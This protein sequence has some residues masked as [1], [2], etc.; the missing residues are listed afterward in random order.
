MTQS[1]LGLVRMLRQN[2][3][4]YCEIRSAGN[5]GKFPWRLKNMWYHAV[6]DMIHRSETVFRLRL[7]NNGILFTKKMPSVKNTSLCIFS[8]SKGI[9]TESLVT[10][11]GL[12]LV[13]F[14]FSAAM[15]LSQIFRETLTS[16]TVTGQSLIWFLLIT[17]LKSFQDMYHNLAY[18]F[19]ADFVLLM[20]L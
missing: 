2:A 8:K 20:C 14:P 17:F 18:I 7:K 3:S 4:S 13:D 10:V 6:Q 11:F 9:F 15:F 12:L 16:F 19:L 5:V 1:E